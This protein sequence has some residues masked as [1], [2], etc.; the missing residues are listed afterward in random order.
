MK[1]T[2]FLVTIFLMTTFQVAGQVTEVC[3]VCNIK[4][5]EK[6]VEISQPGDTILIKQGT[7]KEHEIQISKPLVII[8]EGKP[9]ID[10]EEEGSI[11]KINASGV[12]FS[13]LIIRNVGFSHRKEFAAIH[14]FESDDF[15]I[16]D[17]VLENVFFGILIERS[18]RGI[19][20]NNLILG[21][22]EKE[23]YSGNG[24]HGWNSSHLIINN[25]V[26]RNLRDGIYFEFVDDSEVTNNESTKNIRYGLH[27]M[28]SNRDNYY[29]NLFRKNGAGVAVMFSKHIQIKRNKFHENWGTASFGLLLK[30]IYDTDI[31][32]NDFYRNTI[33][34][35]IEGSTR[36]NYKRNNL[37]ENGWAVKFSGGCYTNTFYRNNFS[38]NSF[39]LSF[40]SN[41]ND[42]LFDH[43]Y[44]SG[45]TGYDLDKNSIGDV[46][47]RPVK[48]F[49]YVVNRTPET[50]IL[51][52][53]FFIDILNFSESVSPVFTPD[54][55]VD[56]NPLMK[57][58]Q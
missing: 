51:L 9:V 10:G 44:W 56:E 6:A 17:N 3:R 57:P 36:I 34:I 48:L 38:Y 16:S 52:R 4:S 37:R 43:N 42:N 11:I 54:K 12:S 8:G 31:E 53:S 2:I 19:I 39:D 1:H 20:E 23:F 18:K 45:Y 14:L 25:N 46:P 7:Y 29:D 22:S 15:R 24:I 26:I 35:S 47:Y 49:S 27:F 32:D 21:S 30:E 58:V 50:V 40:N 28:F 5:L 41:M 13:G 55:L 33:G